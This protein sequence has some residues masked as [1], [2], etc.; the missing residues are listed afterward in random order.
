MKLILKIVIFLLIIVISYS[1]VIEPIFY[2]LERNEQ[3]KFLKL[4]FDEKELIPFKNI[5]EFQDKLL[6][7]KTYL[8][9]EIS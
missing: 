7:K 6:D 5:L 2:R 8:V 9:P 1:F 4:I 3:E